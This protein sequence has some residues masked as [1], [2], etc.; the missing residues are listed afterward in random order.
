M[1][2][3]IGSE[4]AENMRRNSIDLYQRGAEF[5]RQQGIIIADTRF[6]RGLF[7]DA[8]ILIDEVLTPDSSRFWPAA[9]YKP[10]GGQ[11]SYDNQFVRAWLSE[12]GWVKESDPPPLADEIV[13]K[14][15]DKYVEVFE[16]MRGTPFA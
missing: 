16:Q 7:D 9:L 6:A 12:A 2:E 8:L 3:L 4:T 1:V 10:G 5:S 11:P 14:T 15:R 13:T